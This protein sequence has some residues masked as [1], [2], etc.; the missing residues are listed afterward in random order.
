MPKNTR[1]EDVLST[2][3]ESGLVPLE[4][5]RTAVRV[6]PKNQ[7]LDSV[8]NEHCRKIVLKNLAEDNS[9]PEC[10]QFMS[11]DFTSR[12]TINFFLKEN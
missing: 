9:G 1:R 10:E 3:K 6:L 2:S 7:C 12:E 5:I 4:N 11:I 8:D